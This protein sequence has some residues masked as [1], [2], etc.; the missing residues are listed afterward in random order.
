MSPLV[1]RPALVLCAAVASS[2]GCAEVDTLRL[3]PTPRRARNPDSVAV[4]AQEPD[5]PYAVIALV[6]VTSDGVNPEGLKARLVKRAGELGGD[7][8]L[9]GSESLQRSNTGE[10]RLSG[11]VIVFRPLPSES[12]APGMHDRLAPVDRAAVYSAVLDSA[13]SL[14]RQAL[15]SAGLITLVLDPLIRERDRADGVT[16]RHDGEWLGA[17]LAREN[18]LGVCQFLDGTARCDNGEATVAASLSFIYDAGDGTALVQLAV[19]RRTGA[20]SRGR[21]G[22]GAAWTFRFRKNRARWTVAEVRQTAA[23]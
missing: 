12:A 17:Q 18:V 15:K 7:A 3:D 21:G 14:T 9:L 1:S 19:S 13:A 2:G 11:R 16:R 10:R 23:T 6:S 5:R 8:V 22:F 4:I 20:A